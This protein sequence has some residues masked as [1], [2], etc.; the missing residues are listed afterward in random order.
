MSDEPTLDGL[1]KDEWIEQ[2]RK[3][4]MEDMATGLTYVLGGM[5]AA[6]RGE[7]ERAGMMAKA[8]QGYFEE[9]GHVRCAVAVYE[10]LD[11]LLCEL[12]AKLGGLEAVE[13]A[14]RNLSPG[15][16]FAD[17]TNEDSPEVPP[18]SG[19][20]DWTSEDRPAVPDGW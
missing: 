15:S 12:A 1:T 14:F 6:K 13:H 4:A 20:A 8:A 17:W 2:A 11:H 5:L 18:G 10:L 19:F 7:L 3:N 9:I 16:V